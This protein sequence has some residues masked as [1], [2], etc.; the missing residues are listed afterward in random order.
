[1]SSSSVLLLAAAVAT[2]VPVPALAAGA[3]TA[4]SAAPDPVRIGVLFR[5]DEA[6]GTGSPGRAAVLAAEQVH[7][8]GSSGAAAVE[9]IPLAA[10]PP[11]QGAA[12]ALARLIFDHRLSVLLGASDSETAHVAAQVATRAR[13]PF[14]TTSPDR[15]LTRAGDPWIFQGL[16]DD[17]AQARALV[18]WAA[19]APVSRADLV[20][21][22][23]RPGRGITAALRAATEAAG[24]AVGRIA[25]MPGDAGQLPTSACAGLAQ[26]DPDRIVLIWT[27]VAPAA[28]FLACLRE[29]GGR[30]LVL[31]HLGLHHPRLLGAGPQVEGLILPGFDGCC[32]EGAPAAVVRDIVHAV[33]R[34]AV[35]AGP[36]PRAL[37]GALSEGTP[38]AGAT[39]DFS[40]DA[41]GRRDVTMTV[42]TVTQGRWV[43]LP[44]D[45]K[46]SL[47]RLRNRHPA[48]HN[49]ANNGY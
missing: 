20:V 35:Q 47:S 12:G 10:P 32:E 30:Q 42:G 48:T 28:R 29:A 22:A 16:P 36:D 15:T 6:D 21:P 44:R 3:A 39:G 41:S 27:D 13:I 7:A 46:P 11:W 40:F 1:M 9:L 8:G 25:E 49:E 5:P 31:G 14:V 24:I 38:F 17:E 37:R 26:G 4:V 34:A 43:P 23:G 45:P 33:A 19:S 2:G 18:A